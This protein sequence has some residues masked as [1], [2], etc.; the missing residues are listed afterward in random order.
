MYCGSA[1]VIYTIPGMKNLA[2]FLLA[3]SAL[4]AQTPPMEELIALARQGP[5]APGLKDQIAK[6]RGARNGVTVWGQDYLFVYRIRPPPSPSPSTA[7][8]PCR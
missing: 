7:S 8:R 2:L 3:S 4:V 1:D 5:A 6:T